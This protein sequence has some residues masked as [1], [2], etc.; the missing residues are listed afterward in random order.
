M[1]SERNLWVWLEYISVVRVCCCKGVYRFPHN[2]TYPYSTCISSFVT[3]ASLLFCSL[4]LSAH[5]RSEGY[6]SCPVCMCVCMSTHIWCFTHWNHK[7]EKP[8]GSCIAIQQSF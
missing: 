8:T 4:T 2:I 3:T 7:T 6:C 5:A 1:A